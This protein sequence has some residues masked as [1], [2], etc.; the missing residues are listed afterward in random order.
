[1][2]RRVAVI[3]TDGSEESITSI[4]RVTK[5]SKIGTTSAVTNNRGVLRRNTEIYFAGRSK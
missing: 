2:L 4:M 1:M 3:K 5:I